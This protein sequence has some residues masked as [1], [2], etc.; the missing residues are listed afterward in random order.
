MRLDCILRGG[1][2]LVQWSDEGADQ[3]KRDLEKEGFEG[4]FVPMRDGS[5]AAGVSSPAPPT[6]GE[7]DV[8]ASACL[9]NMII[10]SSAVGRC[11]S[12]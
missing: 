2:E 10:I 12:Y 7:C 1:V 8:G 4:D 3:A 9:K 11:L 6:A 5:S